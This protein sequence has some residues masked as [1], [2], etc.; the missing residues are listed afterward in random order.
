MHRF[1]LVKHSAICDSNITDRETFHPIRP[2]K[3]V[4]DL[5]FQFSADEF[6]ARI[7]CR[8]KRVGR[9]MLKHELVTQFLL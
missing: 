6:C 1:R 9:A 4:E 8:Q 2:L 5:I 3:Q 7:V